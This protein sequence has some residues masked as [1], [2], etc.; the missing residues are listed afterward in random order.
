[1]IEYTFSNTPVNTT[2]SLIPEGEYEV[3]L[4]RF[5]EGETPNGKKKLDLMFRMKD[6]ESQSKFRGRALFDTI[7]KE[8]ESEFYNRKRLNMLMGTQEFEDGKTF[9]S[10]SEI[11]QELSQA[12]LRIKV[13]IT[14]DDYRKEDVNRIQYYM[15]SQERPKKVESK[16]VEISDDDLPF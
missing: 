8:R 5:N 16:K 1:M 10:I 15:S 12:H 9:S 2:G 11:I 6:I 14:Y 13:V 4:E 3:I 7:W